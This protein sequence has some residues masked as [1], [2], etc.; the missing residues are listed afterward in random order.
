MQI[1]IVKDFRLPTQKTLKSF[2][3]ADCDGTANCPA[4]KFM[5]S[6]ELQNYG[7]GDYQTLKVFAQKANGKYA[8][9][10]TRYDNN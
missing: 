8:A 10:E 6:Y 7:L 5:K 3:A 1:H 9:I 2:L 4:K